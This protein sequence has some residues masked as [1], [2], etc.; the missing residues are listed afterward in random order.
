MNRE[1]KQ[2][3]YSW[4]RRYADLSSSLVSKVDLLQFGWCPIK[5]EPNQ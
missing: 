1:L 4:L 3:E 5:F 2:V